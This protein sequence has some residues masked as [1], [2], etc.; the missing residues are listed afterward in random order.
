M[1]FIASLPDSILTALVLQ[2]VLIVDHKLSC[3]VLSRDRDCN[4]SFKPL[5]F[6]CVGLHYPT[7]QGCLVLTHIFQISHK[8]HMRTLFNL[9]SRQTLGH[10]LNVIN[11]SVIRKP[12]YIYTTFQQSEETVAVMGSFSV[13]LGA[14]LFL[15]LILPKNSVSPVC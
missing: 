7:Q 6:S 2:I 10:V 9:F 4:Q 3:F 15:Q 11:I 12:Y 1:S 14:V 8:H 13:P 5:C